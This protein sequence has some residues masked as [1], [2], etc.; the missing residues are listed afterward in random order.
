MRVFIKVMLDLLIIILLVIIG[1][2]GMQIYNDYFKVKQEEKVNFKE[3]V[4]ELGSP[5]DY[6]E[7]NN[8]TADDSL[9]KVDLNKYA[10]NQSIGYMV[11]PDINLMTSIIKGDNS[12]GL[13]AAMNL[14]VSIDPSGSSPGNP[15][16][17]VIAG[18]REFAFSKLEN[19]KEGTPFVINID[20]QIYLYEVESTDIIEETDIDKVFFNDGKERIVLYTCYPFTF[21]SKVTNRYAVYLKPVKQVN[22]NCND[23]GELIN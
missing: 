18:H 5:V 11:A 13:W 10:S 7:N 15:G 23:L 9:P 22:I 6:C 12:D 17:T 2:L 4:T 20:G 21:N 8:I 19:I 3:S 14:G 1:I 16:N